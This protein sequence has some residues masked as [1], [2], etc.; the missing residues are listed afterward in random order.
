M[1]AETHQHGERTDRGAVL[2]LLVA[3]VGIDVADAAACRLAE[4][5]LDDDLAILHL[6]AMVAEEFG[7][8]T[9]GDFDLDLVGDRPTTLGDL[10]ELFDEAL[11]R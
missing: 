1:P 3:V 10:V 2:D 9:V 5:G 4:L 8:R 7:E 11:R 6:W